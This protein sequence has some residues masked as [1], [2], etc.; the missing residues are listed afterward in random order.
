MVNLA[1]RGDGVLVD[2][3]ESSERTAAAASKIG[4]RFQSDPLTITKITL[5]Q[6]IL[7]IHHFC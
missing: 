6:A 7:S 2:G 4:E 3:G 5:L 1:N